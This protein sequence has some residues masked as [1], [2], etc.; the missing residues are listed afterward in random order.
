VAVIGTLFLMYG[1]F[2]MVSIISV[3]VSASVAYR[4][5]SN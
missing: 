5:A 1:A 4:V 2:P 3:I